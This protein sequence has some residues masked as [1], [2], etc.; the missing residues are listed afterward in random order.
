MHLLL[1]F[2]LFLFCLLPW[3][4]FVP[5][6]APVW[7]FLL[8]LFFCNVKVGL[9]EKKQKLILRS[10]LF[11]SKAYSLAW[12]A[13]CFAFSY[14]LFSLHPP[15]VILLWGAA[16]LLR[17]A[18]RPPNSLLFLH[19][20]FIFLVLIDAA[21]FPKFQKLPKNNQ[22]ILRI[23]SG[24][25]RNIFTDN[26]EE[27][28]Y[29]TAYG[30]SEKKGVPY[31]TFFQVPLK[32][33]GRVRSLIYP[34]CYGGAYD[35]KRNV[36]YLLGRDTNELL[37]VS[38]KSM[39]VIRTANIAANP[40]GIYI[41][42]KRDRL[43]LLFEWRMAIYD[44]VL[45]KPLSIYAAKQGAN[46]VQGAVL[47]KRDSI[48]F[49]CFTVG[50]IQERDLKTCSIKRQLRFQLTPWA[51]TTDTKENFI[52]FTDFLLGTLSVV[53]TRSFSIVKRAR[54]QSGIRP[55]EVDEKRRLVYTGSFLSPYLFVLDKNLRVNK[56]VF[57]GSPC[58]AIKLLKDGRLF[59]GTPFGLVE[60]KIDT[61]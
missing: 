2:L 20:A 18:V 15:L 42:E 48:A 37:V 32:K 11:L 29:F 56:K 5:L 31:E 41:D 60:V 53:D 17:R 21:I 39:K 38:P 8:F 12:L 45:L 3:L 27:F 47:K 35:K 13:L 6:G 55:V 34:F 4:I 58:R 50:G 57:I 49:A 7:I 59:A 22:V 40:A 51:V 25:V 23:S 16:L 36:I 61:L 44:P 26:K 9:A 33:N 24:T 14:F 43:I 46:F 28:L 30:R 1:Y 19:A 54:I 10:Y 52:Y